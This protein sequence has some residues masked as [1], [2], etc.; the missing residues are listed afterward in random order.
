MASALLGDLHRRVGNKRIMLLGVGNRLRGDDGFGSMLVER[1]QGRL[2]MSMID[3]GDVPEN[4]LDRIISAEVELV[5]IVDA[6]NLGAEPGD[7]ALLDL[8]QLQDYGIS[9]HSSSLS[10][11][12]QAIP[13]VHRP[14]GIVLAVQP[15]ST[16]FGQGLSGPVKRTLD[17]LESELVANFGSPA[18]CTSSPDS[19]YP[20][21][22]YIYPPR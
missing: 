5:L 19:R 4:F 2:S 21:T 1:L 11:M 22:G 6:A 15:D 17:C 3:A 7:L 20:L 10:I 8:I 14:E 18:N 12:F 9:T 13:K 16:Q